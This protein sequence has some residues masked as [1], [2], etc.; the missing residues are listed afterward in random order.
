MNIPASAPSLASPSPGAPTVLQRPV[1][2]VASSVAALVLLHLMVMAVGMGWRWDITIT[3]CTGAT[4]RRLLPR[5]PFHV[6]TVTGLVVLYLWKP[7]FFFFEVPLLLALWLL[8]HRFWWFWGLLLSAGLALPKGLHRSFYRDATIWNWV[9]EAAMGHILL[10][11]MLFWFEKRRGRLPD[12]TYPQWMTLFASASNPLNPLN[13][14]PLEMWREPSVNV[15][16]LARSLLLLAIKGSALW[17]LEG[18]LAH[19]IMSKQTY[20]QLSALSFAGLWLTV[21]L[22]YVRLALYLSGTA[23]VAIVV[24]RTFGWHLAHPFRWA[25]LA[26]NPVELWRRW[27][28]YNRKLLIKCFYFPLGGGTKRRYLN[29]MVTFWASALVLHTGWVGS[30]YWIVGVNG[31]RDQTVY[32]T[33]QGLAVCACLMLW[34]RRGKDPAS[35]KQLRL[36]TGRIV[37]T[38]GT[39]AYSALVHIIVMAPT[40]TWGERWRLMARCLGLPL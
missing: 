1:V 22:T 8:R 31:L 35:D 40:V 14:G 36:S 7:R 32:F 34:Q 19:L 21:G 10:V 17:T 27:S 38:L 12:P 26:W 4:L 24:L 39:Q 30:V 28:I 25:L 18:P 23:D 33:L 11:A 15:V 13:L 20:A 37:G 2:E 5:W 9:S 6:M 16:G 29:V 3:L